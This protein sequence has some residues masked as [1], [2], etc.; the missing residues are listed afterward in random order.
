MLIGKVLIV[1]LDIIGINIMLHHVVILTNNN[2]DNIS[3]KLT[4]GIL[5]KLIIIL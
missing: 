2:I 3:F 4:D 5:W 1:N